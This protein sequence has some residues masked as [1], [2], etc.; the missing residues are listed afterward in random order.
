MIM[1]LLS[2]PKAVMRF[3]IALATTTILTSSC[4]T[5]ELDID[6]ETSFEV[7][8]M[9]VVKELGNGE[10]TEIRI[11]VKRTGTY[12]NSPYYIRYFQ[13]E[14]KGR[15]QFF[16]SEPYKPNDTYVLQ[17]DQI[18][19]YYTSES[20]DAHNFDIWFSD[21]SGKEIKLTFQFKNK[22][23]PKPQDN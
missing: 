15:L 12:F 1:K 22:Q 17:G 14:G 8:A 6:K 21:Y 2:K 5:N 11:M 9:P 23:P 18:R 4:N 7:T 10:M 3:L 13:N 20:S 19:L 16:N